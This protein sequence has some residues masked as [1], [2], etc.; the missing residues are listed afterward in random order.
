MDK[1]LNFIQDFDEFIT[2]GLKHFKTAEG[3]LRHDSLFF[4]KLATDVYCYAADYKKNDPHSL[5]RLLKHYT[6]LT[7]LTE[8]KQEPVVL[9][10]LHRYRFLTSM[11]LHQF[12]E[13]TMKESDFIDAFYSY[14]A[15]NTYQSGNEISDEASQLAFKR[16]TDAF[17]I[18][19]QHAPKHWIEKALFRFRW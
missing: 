17:K 5:S 14:C 8:T 15:L 4:V 11:A 1:D 18:D 6:K 7:M 16:K 13:S 2:K 10:G 9:S 12:N 3:N 19:I